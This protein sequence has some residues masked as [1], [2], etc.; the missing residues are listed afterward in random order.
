[1]NRIQTGLIVFAVFVVGSTIAFVLMALA[2][3]GGPTAFYLLIPL[4]VTLVV[5]AV[6]MLSGVYPVGPW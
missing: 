1:M 3:K 6:L 5:S 2:F 4:V